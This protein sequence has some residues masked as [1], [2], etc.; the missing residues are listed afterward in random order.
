MTNYVI[1]KI[2]VREIFITKTNMSTRAHLI[3]E[4]INWQRTYIYASKM[5]C[6][7]LRLGAVSWGAMKEW[8]EHIV[9]CECDDFTI[10]R[11]SDG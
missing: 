1:A 5:R 2:T 9:Y 3:W 6:G 11:S 10:H 7:G 8:G 4:K